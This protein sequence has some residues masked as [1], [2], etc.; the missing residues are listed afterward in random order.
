MYHDTLFLLA[1]FNV[2]TFTRHIS[3]NLPLFLSVV[4]LFNS[5]ND[6]IE[7]LY[8]MVLGHLILILDYQ[9]SNIREMSEREREKRR[10]V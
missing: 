3:L 8:Q 2:P 7:R 5:T 4:T 6:Q 1:L 10:E 9:R